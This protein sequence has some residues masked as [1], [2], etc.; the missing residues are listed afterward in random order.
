[1][2]E[3]THNFINI[4]FIIIINFIDLFYLIYLQFIKYLIL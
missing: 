4:N 3:V 2:I 1:V